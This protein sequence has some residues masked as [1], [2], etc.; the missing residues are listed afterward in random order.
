MEI[1]EYLRV[2]RRRLWLLVGL[3]VVAAAAAA[4]VVLLIPQQYAGTVY[5][6]APALVGGPA[7]QQYT[8]TQG[9]NQFVAAFAAAATSPKVVGQVAAETGASAAALRDGISVSQVGA[10]SQLELSYRASRRATV[11]PVV[12]ATSR[13]ALDFLFASQ[14]DIAEQQ[15]QAASE[16]V[17][18]ATTA[19]T[20]WEK[21]NK[22]SQPDKVYQATLNELASLR[23]Q[24]LSMEAVG[25][26][27]GA[28]AAA[29]AIAAGQRRVDEIGPKLPDYQALL[30]QRDAATSALS[31]AR[32]EL[33]AARAQARAAD[34]A[35]VTSVG[36]VVAVSRLTQLVRTVLPIA[37]AAL[38]VAVLLVLGLEAAARRRTS[39]QP[40]PESGSGSAPAPGSRSGPG[41]GPERTGEV[42]PSVAA[43]G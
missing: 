1:V 39:P 43:V 31:Q 35:E 38:I 22:L 2:A 34:P 4:A 20:G 12:E 27:R 24:R 40:D 26:S 32:Q 42:S 5:V 17:R 28:Q 10:S 25:N 14:V 6:A 36:E 3:P 19:I 30:A 41:A 21:T 9:A 15:V 23:Q 8:G 37:G 29:T 7:A 18:A 13:H 16:D 11:V 33:Q